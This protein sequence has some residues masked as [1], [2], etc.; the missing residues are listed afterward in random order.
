[1]NI[2]DILVLLIL[3]FSL[4]AGMYKG[5][6]SSGLS[7]LGLIGSWFGAL[8]VYPSLARLALSQQSLMGV[9]STY[10]E[11]ETFFE[12]MNIAGVSASTSVSGLASDTI[13]AVADFIGEKVP[14]L[15]DVFASNVSSEAF[16]ALNIHTLAEYF[17]QTLWQSVF[18]VLAFILAFI[19][20]YFIANLLVNLFNHVFR[21][22]L[23]R[24]IDWALGGV[25]GLV[26]GAVFATLILSVLE[27][28][29][30]AFSVD[31]MNTLKEGSR[32]YAM[33]GGSSA[34]D[35]LGVKGVI[36]GIIQSGSQLLT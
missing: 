3:A 21:F 25:L 16:S 9:L 19:A 14:F 33:F 12:G 4:F 18:G 31:L 28:T 8:K 24:K 17:D 35:P 34:F 22:P 32:M 15:R 2:I 30:S 7:L 26:R 5:F 6:I 29:L 10:L 20:F 23:I 36:D 1:M 13:N 11:P 27:P